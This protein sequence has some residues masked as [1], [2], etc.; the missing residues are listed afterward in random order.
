MTSDDQDANNAEQQGSASQSEETS[1]VPEKTMPEEM[2][3]ELKDMPP[4]VRRMFMASMSSGP[5]P[6]PIFEK[7]TRDHITQIIEQHGQEDERAY[8]YSTYGR[9]YVFAGF[10]VSLIL[11]LFILIYFPLVGLEEHI[12]VVLA[13][14]GGLAA[15][16]A[17]G[18]GYARARK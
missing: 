5:V 10:V 4:A 7:V 3:E 17:G 18:Y 11:V 15:G 12:G 8:N 9:R 14:L 6:N 16:F 1:E 13:G 2:A